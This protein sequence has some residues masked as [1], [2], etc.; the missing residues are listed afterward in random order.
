MAVEMT[1]FAA[2]STV[3]LGIFADTGYGYP[4]RLIVD[5][6]TAD[7]TTN[8]VKEATIAEEI[9][10]GL[11]WLGA[12]AQGGNPTLRAT[13]EPSS[14]VGLSSATINPNCGY[15]TTSISGALPTVFSST[16]SVIGTAPILWVRTQYPLT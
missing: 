10:P 8:G 4:G 12:V 2:A 15:G 14:A 9:G 1:T 7:S 3:R 6:G 16:V 5:A 13:N 11:V